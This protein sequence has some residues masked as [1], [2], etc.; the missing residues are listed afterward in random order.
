MVAQ[1][2]SGTFAGAAG[3]AKL[4]EEGAEGG[5]VYVPQRWVKLKVGSDGGADVLLSL[6]DESVH[7]ADVNLQHSLGES[8]KFPLLGGVSGVR[9]GGACRGGG[10]SFVVVS[11]ER[12][13]RH[14]VAGGRGGRGATV[15]DAPGLWET[16]E[17]ESEMQ[18]K[19][20]EETR[21]ERFA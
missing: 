20:L 17:E 14:R 6:G 19:S 9:W 11:E 5:R 8:A 10:G 16:V 12:G 13:I 7:V 4:V 15:E 18:V 3:A 1:E 21:V 2:H